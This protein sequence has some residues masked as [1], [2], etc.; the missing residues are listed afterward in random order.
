MIDVRTDFHF[1]FCS[2]KGISLG[3]GVFFYVI[4]IMYQGA[5]RLCNCDFLIFDM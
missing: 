4:L 5:D 3:R 1:S 2:E